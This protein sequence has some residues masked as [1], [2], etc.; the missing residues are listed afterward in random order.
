MVNVLSWL[1]ENYNL[2]LN[3]RNPIEIPNVGRN[4]LAEWFGTWGYKEVAE[5]GV[6]QGKFSSVITNAN[7]NGKLY[8][9]DLWET[10]SGYR[11]YLNTEFIHDAQK[12][13]EQRLVGKKV[14]FCKGYSMDVVKQ[15]KDE[16]L[17]AVYIDANHEF[18]WVV[19]D[20][21]EWSKKVKRGGIISGH[22]YYESAV[23][24]SRCQVIPAVHG[25][26]Q[27]YKITPWFVLGTKAKNPG[28][29][30]DTSRSWMWVKK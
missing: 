26:T 11:D 24:R 29:I 7:P 23:E 17:D 5:I 1:V 4:T 27:A 8:C 6:E 20:I 28:E 3:K 15:F 22:D 12:I 13:A 10:Y 2:D 30:R 14:Q 9:V 16:S 18:K 19:E 21:F 25:H